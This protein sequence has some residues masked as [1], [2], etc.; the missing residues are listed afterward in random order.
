M[1]EEEF[2]LKGELE[3]LVALA[4]GIRVP[5][6]G[7]VSGRRMAELRERLQLLVDVVE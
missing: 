3:A 5:P 2:S 4:E 7:T 6:P 1:D